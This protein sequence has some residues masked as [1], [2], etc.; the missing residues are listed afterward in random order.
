MFRRDAG[1]MR[2]L[3]CPD[4]KVFRWCNKP[5]R[6]KSNKLRK[7]RST[8]SN[9]KI[10][11]KISFSQFVIHTRPFSQK[12]RVN[13]KRRGGRSDN[14]STGI[15]CVVVVVVADVEHVVHSALVMSNADTSDSDRWKR[16][17]L[18]RHRYYDFGKCDAEEWS[19]HHST[20][21]VCKAYWQNARV[22]YVAVVCC[23]STKYATMAIMLVNLSKMIFKN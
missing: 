12:L 9:E 4:S 10:T 16:M 19:P 17:L 2:T 22:L 7:Y 3:H 8:N 6:C 18:K 1:T 20:F 15:R 13:E 21:T 5:K 14:K 11:K 23:I